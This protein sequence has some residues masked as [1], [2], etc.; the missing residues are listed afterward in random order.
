MTIVSMTDARRQMEQLVE[1]AAAGETIIISKWGKP[2]V[3][4]VPVDANAE[5]PPEV[6]S[7]KA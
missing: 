6:A 2:L 4:L 3:R 7:K 1:R 5:H